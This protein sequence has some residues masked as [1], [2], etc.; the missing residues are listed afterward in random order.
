MAEVDHH[1]SKSASEHFWNI[2][3]TY[4]P[5]IAE[6]TT[7]RCRKIPQFRTLRQKMDDKYVPELSMEVAYQSKE[8]GDIIVLPDLQSTPVNR[9]KPSEFTK[10]YESI[11]IKV[12]Y[13]YIYTHNTRMTVFP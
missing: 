3:K 13:I 11:S 9:F 8:T 6:A 1:V 2:A 10:I 12:I 5:Q 4:F 7:Q